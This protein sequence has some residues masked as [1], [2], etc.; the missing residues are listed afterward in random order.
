MQ[1]T[2]RRRTGLDRHRSGRPRLDRLAPPRFHRPSAL[3]GVG[4]PRNPQRN[5]AGRRCNLAS[6]VLGNG[7]RQCGKLQS[8]P[9]SAPA[10]YRPRRLASLS[11]GLSESTEMARSLPLPRSLAG[12]VRVNGAA[13]PLLLV[14][15]GQI[16]LQAPFELS[17]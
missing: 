10:R 6:N 8:R 13:A 11:G 5:R 15:P 7:R 9:C 3:L 1:S 16:N 2:A 4:R 12:V 17:G 14:S